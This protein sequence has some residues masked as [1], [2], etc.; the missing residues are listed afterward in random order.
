[1]SSLKQ[2]GAERIS[3]ERGCQYRAKP[4]V[5]SDFAQTLA[6]PSP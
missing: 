5:S 4:R 2:I 1:M 6:E 3:V